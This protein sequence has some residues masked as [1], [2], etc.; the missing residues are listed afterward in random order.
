MYHI[1]TRRRTKW[2]SSIG[3]KDLMLQ[4]KVFERL[5]KDKTI[6]VRIVDNNGK[7]IAERNV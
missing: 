2:Q 3:K 4:M 5:C 7:I 1:E 6:S